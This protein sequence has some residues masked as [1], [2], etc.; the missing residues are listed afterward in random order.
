LIPAWIAHSAAV[1]I[2][3]AL[4]ALFPLYFFYWH[5]VRSRRDGGERLPYSFF[6][7]TATVQIVMLTIS[8]LTGDR[9][10]IMSPA[11]EIVLGNHRFWAQIFV[12]AWVGIFLGLILAG[13]KPKFRDSRFIAFVLIGL[14]IL[15]FLVGVRLGHLG[16]DLLAS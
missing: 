12:M 15:Q 14:L 6:V 2:P 5:G 1:H 9:D 4:A 16:G 3:M 13:L 8:F 10:K 7:M 11:S